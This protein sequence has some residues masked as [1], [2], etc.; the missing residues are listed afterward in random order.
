MI[1]SYPKTMAAAL[2]VVAAASA[3]KP[4]TSGNGS[5][6]G[7]YFV[8]E[9]LMT[10][11]VD[12]SVT[13]ANSVMG[14]ATFDGNGNYTFKGQGAS[15]ASGFNTAVSLTGTYA[16]GSNGIFYMTSL[17]DPTDFDYGGVSAV[18]PSAFVASA[19]EGVNVTMMVGIPAG[20]NVSNS[21]FKGSYTAGTIDFPNAGI[22]SVREATFYLAPDGAGNLGNVAVSGAGANLGG[23]QLNQTASGVTYSLS[24]EGIGTINFGAAAS[25]RLVSGSK[26][27]YISADGNIILGGSPGGFDMLVGI[28][29]VTGIASTNATANGVYYTAAL[30]DQVDATGQTTNVIDAFYGSVNATGA[31]TSIFHDQIQW[32]VSNF[33]DYTF[34]SHYAV[35]ANG[36]I[37]FGGDTPYQYTFGVNGRAFIATGDV[38]NYAYYSLTLGLGMPKYSGSGV[39]LS[40]NGIV[41]SANFAPITNPIAPNEFITLFGTGMASTSAVLRSKST[42]SPPLWT[43]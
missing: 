21:S 16:V 42:V 41:N 38:A 30:E 2:F 20:S 1:S 10:G 33:Y 5:L 12:G 18:G 4:D 31:G 29:S 6:K 3:Q 15:L 34:D 9:V 22:A 17:A 39:Y 24:G 36:V 8:R 25:S 19:T 26:T 37:P 23:T 35:A 14:V 11:T 40:P 13:A 32:L 43:T 27:F 7:D 28:R